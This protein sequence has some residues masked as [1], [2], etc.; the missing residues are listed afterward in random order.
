MTK[1]LLSLHVLAAIVAV[2][3]V[4]VAA[5]MFPAAARRVPVP[6][7]GGGAGG[8]RDGGGADAGD[9]RTVRL[10]HRICRVYAGLGIAVPVLGFATAASM[11]VLGDAWLITS[12]TLTAV[13][14]GLLAAFVLPRQEELLGQLADGQPVE[15]AR[16]VRLAMFTG[17]FNLLWATVTILMIVRPGSTTGA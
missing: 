10:L 13:A 6:V 14:A 8:G 16:T 7:P 2:G 4:T 11:G 3:P 5:S 9:V 12:V 15:R 1:F 17:L